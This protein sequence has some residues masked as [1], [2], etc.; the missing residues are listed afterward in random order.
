ML[1]DMTVKRIKA[2]RSEFADK[3]LHVGGKFYKAATVMSYIAAIYSFVIFI[4]QLIGAYFLTLD[5][6]IYNEELYEKKITY[7]MVYAARD[8][9][10][11]V[12]D[13]A[14][15]AYADGCSVY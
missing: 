10:T 5:Y 13:Y 7:A 2:N 12:A 14:R 15:T 1:R 4:A 9:L 3:N 6:K 11:C 8:I